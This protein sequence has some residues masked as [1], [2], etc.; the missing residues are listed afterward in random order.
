MKRTKQLIALLLAAAMLLV[1]FTGCKAE[2]EPNP[3][4]DNSN[5]SGEPANSESAAVTEPEIK[6]GGN[7]TVSGN[8]TTDFWGVSN[9]TGGEVAAIRCMYEPLGRYDSEGNLQPYLADS[10]ETDLENNT[11]TIN[12]TPKNIFQDGSEFNAEVVKWNL[13][14]IKTYSPS[15]VSNF[16]ECEVN[17]NSVVVHFESMDIYVLDTIGILMM[18]SK[19]AYESHVSGSDVDAAGNNLEAVTWC[20]ANPSGSGAFTYSAEDSTDAIQVY[21]A[22]DGYRQEGMPYLDSITFVD[23]RGVDANTIVGGFMNGDYNYYNAATNLPAA[24]LLSENGVEAVYPDGTLGDST[25]V[26]LA[27]NSVKETND[28]GTPNALRDANVRKAL[29]YAIDYDGFRVAIDSGFSTFAT[30]LASPEM[31]CYDASIEGYPTN[32]ETAKQLLTAAGY[33]ESNKLK[34]KINS[35]KM[36]MPTATAI[37]GSWNSTGLVD[38]EIETVEFAAFRALYQSAAYDGFAIMVQ[39]LGWHDPATSILKS[40]D[41]NSYGASIVKA[42]EVR[43]LL[44]EAIASKDAAQRASKISAAVKLINDECLVIPLD[45]K[46]AAI[47]ETSNLHGFSQSVTLGSEVSPESAWLE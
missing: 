21:K 19:Q 5:P 36:N 24:K 26:T 42:D 34:V 40:F 17:G 25:V 45:L 20:K 31:S 30:Q 44:L 11:L 2:Q 7:M 46:S 29:A 47:F 37:Q 3:T 33:S 14:M 18:S 35:T 10:F 32:L 22:W 12:V 28:D 41:A 13:D 39:G 43:A 27:P 23:T 6:R 15:R 1:C 4:N 8:P 16:T 9:A 38:C